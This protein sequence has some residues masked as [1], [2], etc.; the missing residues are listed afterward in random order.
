VGNI[1]GAEVAGFVGAAGT[2]VAFGVHA[3]RTVERIKIQ[4]TAIVRVVLVLDGFILF[5]S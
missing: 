4:A 5:F 3:E 2:G 1:T